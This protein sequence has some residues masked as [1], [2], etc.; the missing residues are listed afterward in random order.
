MALKNFIKENIV[1]VMGLTLPVLLVAM[2]FFAVVLPRTMAVPPQYKMLFTTTRYNYDNPPP[3]NVDFF[4]KDGILK[5]RVSKNVRKDGH[6]GYDNYNWKKLMSY[7]GKTQSVREMPYDLSKMSNVV[8]GSE[9][10]FDEFK[11][12]KIDSSTKAPD[13]Y[14]FK[15][16]GYHSGGMPMGI[17]YGGS[18]RSSHRVIKGAVSFKI[19]NNGG[20]GYYSHN[21]QFIGWIIQK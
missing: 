21:T 4:V 18:G 9:V 20:N 10:V 8:D 2:F 15:N 12:I 7:D 3:Y 16:S 14:E 1:L 6:S 13:G 17:F 5:A 11:N 19:P